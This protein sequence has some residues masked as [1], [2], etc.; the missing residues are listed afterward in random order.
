MYKTKT[1]KNNLREFHTK[2]LSY[3]NVPISLI[4][5]DMLKKK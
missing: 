3:G 5:E 4:E 1:G 2:F